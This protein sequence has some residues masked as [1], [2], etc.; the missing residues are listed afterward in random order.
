MIDIVLLLSETPDLRRI[1]NSLAHIIGYI[2]FNKNVLI[3]NLV[4]TTRFWNN[5]HQVRTISK[6]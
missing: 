4:S 5:L 1:S 3:S 6:F 2:V